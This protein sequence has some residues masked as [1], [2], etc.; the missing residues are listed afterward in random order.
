MLYV[1][2]HKETG[3]FGTRLKSFLIDNQR[4]IEI[5]KPS[6]DEV[7]EQITLSNQRCNMWTDNLQDAETWDT[8]YINQFKKYL[9]NVEF[10][11]VQLNVE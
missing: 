7:I 10:V 4:W 11:K 9:P 5:Q 8:Y 6:V 2:K 3:L 1:A